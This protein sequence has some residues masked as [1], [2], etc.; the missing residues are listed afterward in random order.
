MNQFLTFYAFHKRKAWGLTHINTEVVSFLECTLQV[1]HGEWIFLKDQGAE[2]VDA[3]SQM[4]SRRFTRFFIPQ[5]AFPTKPW[6]EHQPGSSFLIYLW[7]WKV[8]HTQGA[9]MKCPQAK[10]QPFMMTLPLEGFWVWSLGKISLSTSTHHKRN[11]QGLGLKTVSKEIL[12]ANWAP[13]CRAVV[14][15][16]SEWFLGSFGRWGKFQQD[17]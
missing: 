17:P 11:L 3:V 15:A 7:C 16:I 8:L 12:F 6:Q 9:L 13:P 10:E 14:E 2:A 4:V 1:Q 5:W